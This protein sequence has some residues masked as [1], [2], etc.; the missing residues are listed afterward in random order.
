MDLIG[1]YYHYFYYK[2]IW[3]SASE[4]LYISAISPWSAPPW[5][6]KENL[7]H[8]K[9]NKYYKNKYNKDV[10]LGGQSNGAPRIASFLG[11]SPDNQK[12]ISGAIFTGSHTGRTGTKIRVSK[13]KELNLPI[14]VIHHKRDQCPT[15][16]FNGAKIFFKQI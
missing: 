13:I 2:P 9:P 4:T 5:N 6:I 1:C 15:S 16:S 11:S 3:L 10:W 14:A 8:L 12:L 7:N